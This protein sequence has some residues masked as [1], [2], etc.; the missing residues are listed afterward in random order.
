MKKRLGDRM[1]FE[2]E[3]KIYETLWNAKVR[4]K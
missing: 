4:D 1:E 3:G 2:K